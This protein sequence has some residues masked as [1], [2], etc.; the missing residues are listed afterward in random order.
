MVKNYPYK[1]KNHSNTKKEVKKAKVQKKVWKPK[2]TH[3][4]EK[5]ENLD[6][7]SQVEVAAKEIEN[8][9]KEGNGSVVEPMKENIERFMLEPV[10]PE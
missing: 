1:S 2:V 6:L 8:I 9:E 3:L 10:M 5:Q 4:K 7:K